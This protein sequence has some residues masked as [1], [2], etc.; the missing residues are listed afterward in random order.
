MRDRTRLR[1]LAAALAAATVAVGCAGPGKDN[2]GEPVVLRM[3]STQPDLSSVPP[4]AYFVRRVEELSG[5]SLRI[6]ALDAW[7]T[8][9][10][11]HEQQLVHAV[12]SGSVDLGWSGAGVFD[13][14]GV[15]SLQALQAPMLI[16]SYALEEA[17]IKSEIPNQMLQGLQGHG[18]TG[19]GIL[20][21]GLRKPIAVKA[22]LLGPADWRG[23]HFRVLRS[24]GEEDAIRA[25][26]AI[27]TEV[28]GSA[29]N[30]GLA[31]GDIDGV[32]KSLELYRSDV[33]EQR[34]PYVTANVNLWP[35]MDVLIANPARLS[36][37]TD[38]QRGWLR[39]AARDAVIHSVA[40]DDRDAQAVAATCEA[41]ARF[42]N[43]SDAD[44]AALREAFAPVYAALEDDGQTK[45]L[46]SRIETL[47]RSTPSGPPLAIPPECIGP[48]N[49]TP[50]P[51][52]TTPPSALNGIYRYVLTKEDALKHGG[53]DDKT[54]DG[55]AAFPA[56]ATVT[57]RD[58]SWENDG[59]D[60]GTYEIS[61][62]RVIFIWPRVGSV[63]TFIYRV[64]EKGGLHLEPVLPMDQGDRFVWSTEP[65]TKIG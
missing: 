28:V 29:F 62:D 1:M 54:S 51:S 26:G 19:L 39:Q 27:P 63:L 14:L 58:G 47:K 5:G 53:P 18:V 22:P 10:P 30:A 42:T 48:A 8:Q 25:L 61:G 13:T 21:D 6:H 50:T 3:A 23:I 38:A 36:G 55:L 16:D 56:V 12:S 11:D 33:M 9:T 37:L 35:Q 20:A 57:L 34:A 59:G 17:V 43:A 64:D 2:T 4:V 32:E 46:I 15:D 49:P 24:D 65:W 45:D 44:L 52:Q 41:G 60:S 40:L 7:G 31:N